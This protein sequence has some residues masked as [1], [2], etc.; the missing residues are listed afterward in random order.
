MGQKAVTIELPGGDDRHKCGNE[1]HEL[2]LE[3][4]KV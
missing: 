4:L 2:K 1:G 3:I